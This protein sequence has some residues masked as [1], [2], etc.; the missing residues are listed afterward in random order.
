[1]GKKNRKKSRAR[2][3]RRKN[4]KPDDYFSSG[5]FHFARYGNITVSENS[6]TDAQFAEMQDNLVERFPEVC[7][8]IDNKISSITK[9]VQSVSPKE[10][11]KRAYWEMAYHHLDLKSESKASHEAVMSMRM[12]DYLQSIIASVPQPEPQK[13]SPTD[14][15]WEELKALVDG[16]F[17]QLTLEYQIC[18]TAV[19]RR[20]D[21]DL[22]FAY[23]EYFFKAQG[24]WCMVRGDRYLVHEL[25]FLEDFLSPHADV[26]QD[27]FNLS[28]D[29]LLDGLR[30][31]Q[32]SLTIGISKVMMDVKKF[33]E[34]TMEKVEE[35]IKEGDDVAALL[36]Q[37]IEENHWEGKKQDIAGRLM[38]LDL[39]DLEK[40]T[41]WP[42]S[43]LDELSWEPGQDSDFFLEGEYRGWPL[44]IW[45]IFK[46]PFLKLDGKYFCFELYNLYDHLYRNFQRIFT[47]NKPEYATIWN[48]KQKI[49]SEQIPLGLFQKLLPNCQVYSNVHYRWHPSQ[50]LPKEWCETDAIIIYQD[51]LL[52]VEMRAG[53][54][55][56]TPPA[57]DFPAYIESIRN[58]L[59]KPITQGKRFLEYLESK[60]E[61]PLLDSNHKEIGK[62]KKDDFEHIT[63]CTISLDPFTEI[64][65]QA[66]H[67]KKIG[68]EVGEHP[69]WSIS[70]NDLRVFADIFENPLIFLHFLEQR[71]RAFRTDLIQL[72]DEL[73]HL[74][75]YLEHNVYTQQQGLNGFDKVSWTGYRVDI[76]N[77]FSEKFHDPDAVKPLQQQM[78]Q[79]LMEIVDLLA[80]TQTSGSR[81]AASTL[82]DLGGK[83]RDNIVDGIDEILKQQ[84]GGSGLKPLSTHGDSKITTICWNCSP[85]EQEKKWATDHARTVM[86]VN[87]DS[88][89]LL[90]NLTYDNQKILREVN[91]DFLEL[92]MIPEEEIEKLSGEAELLRET[93]LKKAVAQQGKIGRNAPC[94]CGRG[95]KYKNC[96]LND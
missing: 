79:R 87:Q 95:R 67:L 45:P 10:I 18:R 40:L 68:I 57:T 21:P 3:G 83:W 11:M 63:I 48:E 13:N 64:A 22:D 60:E 70:M 46:R 44:R 38:G 1:M 2:V 32:E 9:I 65:A 69:V 80:A 90:F 54:F 73:D 29:D 78:P 72:D 81:K 43:L 35:R 37:V 31:I 33:Q 77:Y 59:F 14:E 52:I 93:R 26:L 8:E 7:R 42:A 55:T 34:L 50:S 84:A 96:C 56:Y 47:R 20:N 12:V 86:L 17:S 4:A 88:E 36:H 23:E 5:P 61:V 53:A 19:A 51:H 75:L 16:L 92:D 30:N 41:N 27:L 25:A 66:H 6:M 28:F 94:P 76:D 91:F 39:F 58:L 85:Q 62:I 89:R 71:M 49:S 15:Q 24:H 82:L 74:G